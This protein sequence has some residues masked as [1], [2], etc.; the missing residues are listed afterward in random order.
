MGS[1]LKKVWW[2]LLSSCL[3]LF[4]AVVLGAFG[5]HALEAALTTDQHDTWQTANRYQFYHG[6]GA[7]LIL[8]FYLVVKP[9]GF[10]VWAAVLHL[11]GIVLFSGSLYFLSAGHLFN[12][13]F[14]WMG[15]I[16][17]LGGLAFAGGW[18]LAMV[19]LIAKKPHV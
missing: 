8:L 5:A 2:L 10:F 17:P 3:I 14:S 1:R 19:G 16:T 18:I 13:S 11:A 12:M 6:L 9:S 4:F 15:P 7:L